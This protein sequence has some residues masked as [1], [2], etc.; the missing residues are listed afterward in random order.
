LQSEVLPKQLQVREPD[1]RP[2][3]ADQFDNKKRIDLKQYACSR[4]GQ[5]DVR[6]SPPRNKVCQLK[7]N[8]ACNK[9]ERSE[10]EGC[11]YGE[12][13]R[14]AAGLYFKRDAVYP[15]D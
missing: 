11:A 1:Y 2:V 12:S 8:G 3:F 5:D 14:H 15:E 4:G 9:H 6:Q 10:Q 13:E 7:G